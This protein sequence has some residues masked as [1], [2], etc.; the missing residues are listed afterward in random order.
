MGSLRKE[1]PSAF[2][3]AETDMATAAAASLPGPGPV[4][5]DARGDDEMDP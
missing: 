4:L 5:E 3:E 1:L 2:V